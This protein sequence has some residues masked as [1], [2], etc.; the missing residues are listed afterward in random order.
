MVEEFTIF[1]SKK[2]VFILVGCFNIPVVERASDAKLHD[3]LSSRIVFSNSDFR[4]EALK[5]NIHSHESVSNL[6]CKYSHF[7]K[8]VHIESFVVAPLTLI[9]IRGFQD[10]L[11]TIMTFACSTEAKFKIPVE[12]I[13]VIR[14]SPTV[15]FGPE[16]LEK[17]FL[18]ACFRLGQRNLM[19]RY[20]KLEAED[21]EKE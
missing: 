5:R 11:S 8:D 19:S 14:N 20:R 13:T 3:Q 15:I 1:H 6:F 9:C 18:K 16:I 21:Y 10:E 7:A 12:S 2:Q 4:V 17:G